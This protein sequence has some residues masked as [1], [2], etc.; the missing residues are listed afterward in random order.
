M[1]GFKCGAWAHGLIDA[2]Q[3]R[4]AAEAVG[5]DVPAVCV[6]DGGDSIGAGWFDSSWELQRGLVVVEGMPTDL[7]L[8]EWLSA[9]LA[10]VSSEVMLEAA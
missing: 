3:L 4:A 2:K 8:D 5:E 1:T 6:E 7:G 9:A 10:G